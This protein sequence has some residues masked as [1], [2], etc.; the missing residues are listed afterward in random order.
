M[1][2]YFTLKL[3]IQD[4]KIKCSELQWKYV[5]DLICWRFL[6]EDLFKIKGRIS[7]YI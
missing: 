2:S 1:F 5:P 4:V 7:N 3:Y 6:R